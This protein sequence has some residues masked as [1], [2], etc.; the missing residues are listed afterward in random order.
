MLLTALTGY[1]Q[2]LDIDKSRPVN[3]A[4]VKITAVNDAYFTEE[5]IVGQTLLLYLS[6]GGCR[7]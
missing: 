1:G 6:I 3:A 2:Q 7:R 5:G 4:D